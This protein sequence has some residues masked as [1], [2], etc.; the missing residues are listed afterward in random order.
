MT[1]GYPQAG[2]V[3][4]QVV[5]LPL[6][7][8]LAFLF[9][10]WLLGLL[11]EV[12]LLH[13]CEHPPSA[14]SLSRCWWAFTLPRRCPSPSEFRRISEMVF[15]LGLTLNPNRRVHIIWQPH[16]LFLHRSAH[17]FPPSS[18]NVSTWLPQQSHP[19]NSCLAK[20]SILGTSPQIRAIASLTSSGF[21]LCSLRID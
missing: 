10:R 2:T 11:R 6:T 9:S 16:D 13:H 20:S 1:C 14:I 18:Q 15:Y 8:P 21:L 4:L 7:A 3:L 12:R 5:W 17:P 19:G